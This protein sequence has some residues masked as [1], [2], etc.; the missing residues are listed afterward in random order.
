S[1]ARRGP[2]RAP[3]RRPRRAGTPLGSAAGALGGEYEAGRSRTRENTKY[4]THKRLAKASHECVTQ[5][6]I[7][8]CS[9]VS[10]DVSARRLHATIHCR[11]SHCTAVGGVREHPICSFCAPAVIVS[12]STLLARTAPSG[13]AQHAVLWRPL[14]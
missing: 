9:T 14:E 10:F 13:G 2:P 12:L 6:R 5:R 3:S 7:R 11:F 8:F 4:V 1:P